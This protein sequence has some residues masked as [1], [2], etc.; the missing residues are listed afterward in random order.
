MKFGSWDLHNP[1]SIVTRL[2][3]E[4]QGFNSRYGQWWDFFFAPALRPVLG[5]TQPLMQWAWGAL[6]PGVKM[7]GRVAEYSPPFSADI[8][9]A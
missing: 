2:R 3:T 6:I 9:K 8:Q 5:P 1:V 4:R 7:P